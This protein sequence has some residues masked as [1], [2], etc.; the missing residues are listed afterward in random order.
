MAAGNGNCGKKVEIVDVQ[1]LGE[2]PN[3]VP[4]EM[5]DI[6][7][8]D[9]RNEKERYCLMWSMVKQDKFGGFTIIINAD[10]NDRSKG[11]VFFTQEE[12][13]RVT[14]E[15]ISYIRRLSG[16]NGIDILND[17]ERFVCRPARYCL[18]FQKDS[19]HGR[20]RL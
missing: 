6:F 16:V 17:L 8:T 12:L 15:K 20:R 9:E 7:L 13:N 1:H 19:Q 4:L 3:G 2:V 10:S 18:A 11:V 5:L 14:I